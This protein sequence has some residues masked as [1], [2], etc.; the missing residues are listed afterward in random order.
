MDEARTNYAPSEDEPED[1]GFQPIERGNGR[2]WVSGEATGTSAWM[3]G[4]AFDMDNFDSH[5]AS[6][7]ISG[8]RY[9]RWYCTSD[10]PRVELRLNGKARSSVNIIA[11]AASGSVNSSTNF[12][13]NLLI[14]CSNIGNLSLSD[15]IAITADPNSG[16]IGGGG[17]T[18]PLPPSRLTTG[19]HDGPGW[20]FEYA[21]IVCCPCDT[22]EFN[23]TTTMNGRIAADG[24][25]IPFIPP[26]PFL[27]PALV[28]L[29]GLP[30]GFTFP[31]KATFEARI[32]IW[33]V[34]LL[35]CDCTP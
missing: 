25:W 31:G 12:S 18:L 10:Y 8:I 19:T 23:S 24:Y 27:L 4:W 2:A 28:I 29:G 14:D 5:S 6:M 3:S 11:T 9:V 21:P 7:V 30:P 35:S 17:V 33:G 20:N 32:D 13:S 26:P 16:S 22:Y 15:T 1:T 34:V